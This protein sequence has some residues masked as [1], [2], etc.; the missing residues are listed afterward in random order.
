MS[1]MIGPNMAAGHPHGPGRHQQEEA[2]LKAKFVKATLMSGT[3]SATVLAGVLIAMQPA[4]AQ[5]RKSLRWTT[6]AVGSY[7]YAIAASMTKIAEQALGGEYTITV[8]PYSS[9]T[10]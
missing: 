8:H 10:V 3:M 4:D 2:M 5:D 1:A 6:S 9:P 7:G